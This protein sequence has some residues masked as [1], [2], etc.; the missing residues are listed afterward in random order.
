[1]MNI[2]MMKRAAA[3]VRVTEVAAEVTGAAAVVA[4]AAAA[5]A[6]AFISR[7]QTQEKKSAFTTRELWMTDPNSTAHL[8][9][10]SRWNSYAVQA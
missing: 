5:E 2:M 6:H 7:V 4:G 1:M 3:A 8:T 10:S 9:G